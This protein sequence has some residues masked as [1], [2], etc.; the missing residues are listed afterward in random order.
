MTLSTECKS[1]HASA[2]WGCKYC[3]EKLAQFIDAV[4]VKRIL[5]K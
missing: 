3:E 4:D 1:G 5:K 2:T